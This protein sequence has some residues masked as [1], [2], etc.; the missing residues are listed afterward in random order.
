MKTL[1]NVPFSYKIGC[2]IPILKL[3]KLV[4]FGC[5]QSFV[6]VMFM[7]LGKDLEPEPLP[8]STHINIRKSTKT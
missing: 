3:T 8:G 6:I 7:V 4:T 2:L 1:N 5:N